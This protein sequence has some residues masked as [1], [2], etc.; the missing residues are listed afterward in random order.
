MLDRVGGY[1]SLPKLSS[2]G[3]LEFRGTRLPA[4]SSFSVGGFDLGGGLQ[5]AA[6]SVVEKTEDSFA[7]LLLFRSF[8]KFA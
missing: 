1:C 7:V 8:S 6:I 3:P 2:E 4:F 5:H